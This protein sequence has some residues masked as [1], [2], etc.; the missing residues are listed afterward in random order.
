[1]LKKME[2]HHFVTAITESGCH[3]ANSQCHAQSHDPWTK[4]LS[5][6]QVLMTSPTKWSIKYLWNFDQTTHFSII[7]S[8]YIDYV[9]QYK[10]VKKLN[11]RRTKRTLVA[12]DFGV[13]RFRSAFSLSSSSKFSRSISVIR[14]W[15]RRCNSLYTINRTLFT[16]LSSTC[17]CS[18]QPNLLWTAISHFTTIRR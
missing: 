14:V 3:I 6:S 5:N 1:M 11:K 9:K 15:Q 12:D 4:F 8:F 16:R 2:M 7:K 18:C 10:Y 13:A 17:I